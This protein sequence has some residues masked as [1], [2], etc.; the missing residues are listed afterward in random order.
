[1]KKTP[2]QCPACETPLIISELR[3]DACDTRVQGNFL[4]PQLLQLSQEDLSFVMDFLRFRGSLK[5]LG[6]QYGISYPTAR[7]RLDQVLLRLGLS[8]QTEVQTE[9]LLTQLQQKEL[10]VEEVLAQLKGGK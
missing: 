9:D 5:D 4:F 7:N 10:S 3:C 1:M 2:T 6:A 8:K